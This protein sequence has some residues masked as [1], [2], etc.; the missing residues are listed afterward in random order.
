MKL[1]PRNSNPKG[2]ADWRASRLKLGI[3]RIAEIALGLPN[4]KD[5]PPTVQERRGAVGG[6]W[7]AGG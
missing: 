2:E 3:P 6:R 1:N 4:A 5:G 7:V